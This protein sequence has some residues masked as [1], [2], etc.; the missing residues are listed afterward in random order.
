MKVYWSEREHPMI[1]TLNSH[2]P[3]TQTNV[4]EFPLSNKS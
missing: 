4:L 1:Y 3:L 2:P